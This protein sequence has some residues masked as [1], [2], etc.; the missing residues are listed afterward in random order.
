MSYNMGFANPSVAGYFG[1]GYDGATSYTTVYKWAFPADTV[2]TTT[3]APDTISFSHGFSNPSVAGYVNGGSS[4]Y[5][6][7]FPADTV[8]WR[9][10]LPVVPFFSSAFANAGV[11][12]YISQAAAGVGGVP[13]PSAAVYKFSFPVFTVSTTTAAPAEMSRHAGFSG[14]L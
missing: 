9:P 3:A 13:T 6:W 8:K 2:S 11:A 4:M 12:G 14:S 10:P 1:R 7:A 5:E